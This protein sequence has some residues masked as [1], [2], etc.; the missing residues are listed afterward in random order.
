M[1]I[2]VFEQLNRK[3]SPNFKLLSSTGID[4]M[5]RFR[6][7]ME[8]GGQQDNPI[9]T[10]FLA[11]IDCSKIPAQLGDSKLAHVPMFN[12]DI[13]IIF[14]FIYLLHVTTPP[15]GRLKRTNL[16]QH[17]SGQNRFSWTSWRGKR[18]FLSKIQLGRKCPSPFSHFLMRSFE[19]IPRKF[20]KT[21]FRLLQDNFMTI[22]K[23]CIKFFL[24][25]L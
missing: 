6:Q 15:I 14:F 3:Q 8:P 13:Y 1:A 18:Q 4:S 5:N 17:T 11:P 7:P 20:A 25:F 10:R 2:A 24:E 22:R 12:D 9:P 16:P 23:S 19:K 21:L